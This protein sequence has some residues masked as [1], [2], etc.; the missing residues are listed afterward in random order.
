MTI[1]WRI[2]G[3]EEGIWKKGKKQ[4]YVRKRKNGNKKER[5]GTILSQR[6]IIQERVIHEAMREQKE[7]EVIRD[8]S[9]KRIK[10]LVLRHPLNYE[11]VLCLSKTLKNISLNANR[12][13]GG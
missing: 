10:I 9:C 1:R 3:S 5:N 11:R 13:V 6:R 8:K 7:R 4:I 12:W 2:K